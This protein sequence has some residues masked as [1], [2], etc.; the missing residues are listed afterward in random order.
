MC[1]PSWKCVTRVPIWVH[2]NLGVLGCFKLECVE[3]PQVSRSLYCDIT[4]LTFPTKKGNIHL[5]NISHASK[6]GVDLF[7]CLMVGWSGYSLKA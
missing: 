2:P 5:Y 1:V 4:T 3:F 6:I 7:F